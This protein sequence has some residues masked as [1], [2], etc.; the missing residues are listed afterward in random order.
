M[1]SR[2]RRLATILLLAVM[3]IGIC[4]LLYPTVSNLWNA[5]HQSKVV[6]SYADAVS[7]MSEEEKEELLSAA[8]AYNEK[9]SETGNRIG[10]MTDGELQEYNGLLD[11]T[12]TGIMGYIEVPDIDVMLAVYHGTS[13]AVLTSGAGHIEGSSLPVGG[14]STHTVISGHRGLPSAKLFTDLD[15]L[16]EG[17]V[18]YLHILDDILTYEIDQILTVEPDELETLDI[19]EGKDFCTLVTCTPYGINSHRL[20]LRGHRIETPEDVLENAGKE[21]PKTNYGFFAALAAAIAAIIAGG[22][23]ALRSY[24]RSRRKLRRRKHHHKKHRTRRQ[25]G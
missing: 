14:K 3:L 6:V 8:R 13:D 21:K 2:Q 16:A 20:L 1:K 17:D 9:L 15:Q 12:G 25:S 5:Y 7:E 11:V 4:L 19:E 24:R 10:E 23:A 18:F 22:R